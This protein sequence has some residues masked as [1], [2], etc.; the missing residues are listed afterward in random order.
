MRIIPM[1]ALSEWAGKSVSENVRWRLRY[2][3]IC[4]V[5]VYEGRATDEK[6][7]NSE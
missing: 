4:V 1:N 3:D 2:V 5:I 6:A 7:D